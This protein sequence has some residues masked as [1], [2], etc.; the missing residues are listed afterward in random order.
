MTGVF[1]IILSYSKQ[2][3]LNFRRYLSIGYNFFIEYRV[4]F[5]IV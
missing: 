4:D 2:E 5:L 1:Y 3:S